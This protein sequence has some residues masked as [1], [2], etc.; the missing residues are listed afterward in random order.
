VAYQ[1]F[2]V[3]ERALAVGLAT[4][5][6]F[7]GIIIAMVATPSMVS[8]LADGSFDISVMLMTYGR[9]T[10][11]GS[12]IFLLL[13]R[14]KPP[15]PPQRDD[16]IS[17]SVLRGLSHIFRQRDMH[18]VFPLFFIGLG[19]FNAVSTCIDRICQTKGLST[20]QTGMVGGI[21]LIAGLVG[22]VILPVLSDKLRKRKAFIVLAMAGMTPG[23]AG[24]AFSQNYTLL[25]ASAAVMGFFLLGAGA[26]VGF[27][28]SAEVTHPVSPRRAV[29]AR[30]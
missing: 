4:L 7:I 10:L 20:D 9:I 1:W 8:R 26:P 2:P 16:Q 15:T 30:S 5:A 3:T 25:L 11:G 28:Y 12:A 18:L 23:L 22:A 27:Q 13:F 14:E 29:T 19:M 24:L 6:Q 17:L 21:M